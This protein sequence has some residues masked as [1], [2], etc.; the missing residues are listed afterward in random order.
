MVFDKTG[1]LTEEGL[2]VSGSWCINKNNQFE[3]FS[4]EFSKDGLL[5]QAMATCHSV[6]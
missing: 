6:T 4:L 1:T 3:N 2:E 5:V